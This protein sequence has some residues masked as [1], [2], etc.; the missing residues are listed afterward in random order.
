MVYLKYLNKLYTPQES[1][2]L[3]FLKNIENKFEFIF[4]DFF[5]KKNCAYTILNLE[6]D[7]NKLILLIIKELSIKS[8]LGEN[9]EQIVNIDPHY[10]RILNRKNSDMDKKNYSKE[11]CSQIYDDVSKLTEEIKKW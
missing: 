4:N 8:K 10:N 7:A 9:Q 1:Q 5:Y 6:T 3:N 11:H 2:Q